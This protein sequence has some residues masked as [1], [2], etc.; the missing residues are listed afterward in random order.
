MTFFKNG[1]RN[2][3]GVLTV[4]SKRKFRTFDTL[5]N[6]LETKINIRSGVRYIFQLQDGK[7]IT[8]LDEII[9]GG[10]S[11]VVASEKQMKKV[12]YGN[13]TEKFWAN[14]PATRGPF[15]KQELYLLTDDKGER[16]GRSCPVRGH[17][18]FSTSFGVHSRVLII[19]CNMNRHRIEK[20]ILNPHT[21][22]TYEEMLHDIKSMLRMP[23][24]GKISLW[25][26]R[27]PYQKVGR[28]AMK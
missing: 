13:S 19:V 17:K 6:W 3:K 1:D 8:N 25:T 2:F 27:E 18:G 26:A 4:V 16:K 12:D 15:R 9:N 14:R 11:Y 10:K 21:K 5:C 23:K 20:V 22:Q 24:D 7:Q 28:H